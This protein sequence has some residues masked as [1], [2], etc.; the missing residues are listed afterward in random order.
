MRGAAAKAL[1]DIHT[2]PET[3]IPLLIACLD[4]PQED[5]PEAAVE[6]LGEYG[7]LSRPALPK[8]IPLLKKP[9]KDMQHA[10]RVTLK[11]IDPEEAAKAGVR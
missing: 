9:D 4:D 5:V 8:L 10:L 7:A 3:I 2:Q 6:A 11:Q 1:G